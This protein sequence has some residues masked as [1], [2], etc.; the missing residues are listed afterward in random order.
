ML[1]SERDRKILIYYIFYGMN[2]QEIAKTMNM[3]QPTIS[4]ML[5]RTFI[6]LKPYFEA[7]KLTYLEEQ[8]FKTA[9]TKYLEKRF[10]N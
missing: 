5:K 3:K 9:K 6:K 7:K 4:R 1:L 8:A 2:Q 10:N